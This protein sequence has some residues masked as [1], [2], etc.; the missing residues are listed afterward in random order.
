MAKLDDTNK[1]IIRMLSDGRKPFSAIAD[2]IG[3]TEN[4]VRARVN[5]LTEDGILS[6]QGLVDPQHVPDIQVAIMGIKLRTLNLE[7]KAR[8]FLTLKGVFS[9]VV[10]TGRYDLIVQLVTGPDEDRSLLNFFKNELARIK[11]IADVETF[12]VYQAHNYHIPYMG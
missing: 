10:V 11:D 4:T 12:V 5:R 6:I 7:E 3:I 9:V 2:E 8:E 1:A